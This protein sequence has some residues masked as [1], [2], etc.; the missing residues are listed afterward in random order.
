MES[1]GKGLIPTRVEKR[2]ERENEVEAIFEEKSSDNFYWIFM[3]FIE[4]IFMN[5]WKRYQLTV[6]ELPMNPKQDI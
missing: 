4:F 5:Q 3:N 2:E 1:R 6:L